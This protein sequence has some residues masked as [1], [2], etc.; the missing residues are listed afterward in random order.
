MHPGFKP[1][2]H[3]NQL[4]R[5]GADD[6][7]DDRQTHPGL[8]GPL[9]AEFRFT[10]DACASPANAL[11]PR[12]WTEAQDCK[13]Q[14]WARERVWINPPYSRIPVFVACAWEKA[15]AGCP[16]IFMLLPA[17]RTEQPWWQDMVEPYRDE[18]ESPVAGV[19]FRARFIKK[20]WP[21]LN[22]G[23]IIKNRTSVS[24]P[25]GLVGLI[26]TRKEIDS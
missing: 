17:N 3:P 13:A 20:R 2:N 14:D 4:K 8:F 10:V 1:K 21:F 15:D 23:A 6:S 12:Y 22:G 19:K 11:L 18:N 7:V 5:R 16:C 24:P 25:F 9:H 26:W